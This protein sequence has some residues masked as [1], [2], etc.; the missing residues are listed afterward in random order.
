MGIQ[1][2]EWIVD[3]NHAVDAL[4]IIAILANRLQ[5]IFSLCGRYQILTGVIIAHVRRGGGIRRRQHGQIISST[6]IKGIFHDL[7][8]EQF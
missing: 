2:A 4:S 3:W 1:N 6:R 8:D 5:Y 7:Q